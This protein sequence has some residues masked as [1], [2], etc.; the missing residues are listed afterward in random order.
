MH[1]NLKKLYLYAP[2]TP[3]LG[4]HFSGDRAILKLFKALFEDI[5]YDV[6]FP[7][8]FSAKDRVGDH[9][10]QTQAIEIAVQETKKILRQYDRPDLF[11]TYHHYYRAPDLLGPSLVQ[12]WG[13]PYLIIESSHAPRR[14][15]G[16]WALYYQK[17]IEAFEAATTLLTINPGD[18]PMLLESSYADKVMSFNPFL[19][20]LPN[21]QR[22]RAELA[23]EYGLDPDRKWLL[24]VA[25]MRWRHKLP[26][27]QFLAEALREIDLPYTLLIIGE[28]EA[29]VEIEEA[30]DGLPACFLG[31]IP[32]PE[33]FDFYE[34]SDILPWPGVNEAI[35]M[36]Y[37]EAQAYGCVP[38]MQS[39]S[40]GRFVID[41]GKTGLISEDK[42]DYVNALSGLIQDTQ[43]CKRMG[44]AARM[45]I[46]EKHSW[47]RAVQEIKACLVHDDK[48]VMHGLK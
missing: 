14:E 46:R 39:K 17:T 2:Q 34:A 9:E 6:I 11:V 47:A 44:E 5:G 23:A 27:Y 15:E 8:H 30:F 42:S 37:L 22:S 31:E 26:S 1:K 29:R 3:D 25:Q 45:H 24:V 33:L 16:P 40:G 20:E 48:C 19:K 10:F 43:H 13:C 4:G 36:C 21:P 12:A 41:P 32:Q 7:S 38:V 35:G 18:A 28:G